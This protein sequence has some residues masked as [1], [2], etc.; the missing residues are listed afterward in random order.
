MKLMLD[1][2]GSGDSFFEVAIIQSKDTKFDNIVS[3]GIQQRRADI[4]DTF[5]N[6]EDVYTHFIEPKNYEVRNINNVYFAVFGTN[7]DKIM[8][9]VVKEYVNNLN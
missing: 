2:L 4:L 1:K 6:N 3:D 8:D 5:R 9:D 7:S